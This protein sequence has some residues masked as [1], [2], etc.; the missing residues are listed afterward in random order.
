[1]KLTVPQEVIATLG[2]A[3]CIAGKRTAFCAQG[4]GSG[5]LKLTE[6]HI[7]NM[8]RRFEKGNIASK[9]LFVG[10]H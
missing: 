5:H 9:I 4:Q 3:R 2:P 1:M 6:R 7:T 10:G 8:L